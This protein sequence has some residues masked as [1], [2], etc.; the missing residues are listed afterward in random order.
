MQP[1]EVLKE[2]MYLYRNNYKVLLKISLLSFLVSMINTILSYVRTITGINPAYLGITLITLAVSLP[3]IYYQFKL[4]VT[5]YIWISD[6][7][8]GKIITF[9]EAF[10]RSKESTWSFIGTGI[11]LGLIIIS[12]PALVGFGVFFYIKAKLLRYILLTTI[13]V[14]FIYL[15]IIYQF[16]PLASVLEK[17]RAR[18]EGKGGFF[19]LSKGLVQ[20]D[21]WKIVQLEIPMMLIINLPSIFTTDLN[22]WVKSLGVLNQKVIT[23]LNDFLFVFI[24]PAVSCIIVVLY[25]TLRNKYVTETHPGFPR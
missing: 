15:A 1:V 17:G 5:M 12:F 3:V 7:Y 16:A 10:K 13:A 22:P 9:S 23:L 25:L 8:E 20:N 14:P 11:L 6:C 18:E 2:S 19:K 24:S 4:A 21:F